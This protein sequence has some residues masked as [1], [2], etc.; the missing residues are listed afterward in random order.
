MSRDDRR[1]RAG[2]RAVGV[3]AV[4]LAVLAAVGCGDGVERAPAP[5]AVREPNVVIFLI[6]TLRADRLTVYGYPKPTSPRIAAL[7][8]RSVVFDDASSAAPWTLP[9]VTSLELS[10]F[11]CDHGVLVDAQRIADAADPIAAKMQRAGYATASYFQNPYAGPLSGLDRGFEQYRQLDAHAGGQTVAGWLGGLRGRPFFLYLHNI[12]PHDPFAVPM[13]YVRGLGDVTPEARRQF[14]E[15][16]MAYRHAT[17]VD[18]AERRP[19]GTTDNT[20]E[21]DRLIASMN[22]NKPAIATMYDAA[23]KLADERVGAVIDV[24]AKAGVWDDTLFILVSDH[25]E[26]MDEHGMWQHD[27]S[28]YEELLHV[29]LIVHFPH[30]AYG[31]RRIGRPVSLVDVVPTILDYLRRPADP[32]ARGQ[33]LMP[34]VRGDGEDAGDAIR[35][36]GMRDNRK[37]YYRPA[38]ERRGDV[39]VALRQGTWKGIYN[40]SVNRLELYDLAHD[41]GE[42]RDL[43]A[44]EPARATELVA[45]A[46][47]WLDECRSRSAPARPPAEIDDAVRRR[48]QALGYVDGPA[49]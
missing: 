21:Q 29:P 6:D 15:D 10:E 48:L 38:A 19:P 30:D 17:R 20:A 18:F 26:E 16:A 33:T 27:Q 23:V 49:H 24:L 2:R 1:R 41:P 37:K 5:G 39:N 22:A 40:A 4:W 9:S 32:G 45:F 7:A 31:G 34:L 3:G 11:A 28:V 43:S 46:R 12:E 47:T 35:V 8:A 44:T 14:R 36:V 13:R 25:G 42:T